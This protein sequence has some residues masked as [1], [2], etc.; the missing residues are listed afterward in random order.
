MPQAF[1]Q[2][3]HGAPFPIPRQAGH[4]QEGKTAIREQGQDE[5]GF[6][7]NVHEEDKRPDGLLQGRVAD[8][9]GVG[10]VDDAADDVALKSAVAEEKDPV[11][12]LIG[13]SSD[14]A[15]NKSKGTVKDGATGEMTKEE[16]KQA[17]GLLFET[18]SGST[19]LIPTAPAER[20][21]RYVAREKTTGVDQSK[22]K[23]IPAGQENS[24]L[25]SPVNG[26]SD[27]AHHTVS[28]GDTLWEISEQYTGSGFN[29]PDVAK[30]NK[31]TN[32]DLIYPDQ[33]VLLPAK[34]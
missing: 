33:Q 2:K 24:A 12:G 27:H 11:K 6:V 8:D 3:D 29:Y 10:A 30:K 14:D 28:K 7:G 16:K 26:T 4:D 17:D 31:I 23:M 18:S 20:A 9:S 15:A 1:D 25:M 22:E 5:E 13:A 32:P 34:K 19:Q 21:R